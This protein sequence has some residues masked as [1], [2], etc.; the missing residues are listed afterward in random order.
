MSRGAEVYAQNNWEVGLRFGDNVSVDGTV[1][2]AHAPRLHAAVYLD[3]FGVAAYG[4][5]V[6]NLGDGP[7][8]LR[9]YAG[10]GPEIFIEHQFDL[11]LAGDLGVEWAFDEV[12]ITVGFDWRPSFR[13]TN[14]A[15]FNTRNWGFV[16]RFML[17]RG[18]FVPAD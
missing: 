7:K 15:D 4:N 16:A 10:A 11:A 12:P 2:I 17:G 13:L 18:T 6:F 14:G 8:N 1:P 9:F 3:R 5:W